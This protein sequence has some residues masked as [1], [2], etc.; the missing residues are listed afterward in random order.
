MQHINYAHIAGVGTSKQFPETDER[1][2]FDGAFTSDSTDTED[3]IVHASNFD[4][5]VSQISAGVRVLDS[6]KHE[7][8][9][10]GKTNY[11][12]VQGNI[13][14]G[15]FYILKGASI[16]GTFEEM[17]L[18]DQSYPSTKQWIIGLQDGM[19]DKLSMGW[20]AD[21]NICNICQGTIYRYPCYHYPGETFAITDSETG[22]ERLEKCTYTCY[23]ITVVEISLVYFGA[24]KDARLIAKAKAL[25][26]DN[27]LT[28]NQIDH[29]ETQL[30]T[31]IV[32]T[33][34]SY[35]DMPLTPEDK[36]K[37]RGSSQ[38]QSLKPPTSKTPR[39]QSYKQQQVW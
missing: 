8:N 4:N 7:T 34:R 25:A 6:H 13:V 10:L 12:Q 36:R 20:Y 18:D 31:A 39:H 38:P 19:I 35:F 5:I 17:R 26:A 3:R 23:G 11:A 24:N 37:S 1:S 32:N 15:S 22:E 2:Y 14:N 28:P 9:G 16:D 27:R 21:R 30:N 29:I 33:E